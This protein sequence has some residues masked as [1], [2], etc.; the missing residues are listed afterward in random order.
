MSRTA[1]SAGI[2][3]VS[4]VALPVA[5]VPAA[6]QGS[7]KTQAAQA[8]DCERGGRNGLLS[9]VTDGLCDVVGTVTGTVDKLT[10]G[11]TEPLTDGL[12]KTTDKVLGTVGEA[13]PTTKAA[14]SGEP[15][16]RSTP[17]T[18]PRKTLLPEPLPD[19]CLPLACDDADEETDEDEPRETTPP[20]PRADGRK[21]PE[22][23]R[24]ERRRDPE[25]E[26]AEAVP[27][28]WPTHP[29]ARETHSIDGSE[30]PVAEEPAADPEDLR[31]DLLWPNPFTEELPLPMG[32]E[33]VVRPVAPAS[34]V[35]GTTLTVVLLATA[36]LASRVVQQRRRRSEPHDSMPFEPAGRH[37]LA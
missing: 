11:V 29:P 17:S 33:P 3:A 26:D 20:S 5:A 9:G 28:T 8:A 7:Q 14:P 24:E 32:R 10:G 18:K 4:I 22:P 21:T 2:L 23:E 37:R 13:L 35:L 31:I 16:A 12:D 34:D 6:A 15:S 25:E 30:E 19:V 36:I 1:I 27:T